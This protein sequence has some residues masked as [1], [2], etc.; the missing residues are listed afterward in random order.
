MSILS[1]DYGDSRLGIAYC[2]DG[3]VAY[4]LFVF[5]TKGINEKIERIKEVCQEY[6]I[7]QI[8]IGLPLDQKGNLSSQ[9]K[10]IKEFGEKLIKEVEPPIYY[11]NE[12]LTSTDAL[13]KMIEAGVPRDKRKEL[14]HSFAAQIVLQEY[15]NAHC[16]ERQNSNI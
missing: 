9:A 14:E 10:E 16:G 1:I 6:E 7:S 12:T 4:P 15:L 2:P 13:R 11:W 5:E 8:V 3:Q